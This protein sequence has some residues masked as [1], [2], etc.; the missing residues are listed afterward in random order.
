MPTPTL[1]TPANPVIEVDLNGNPID[2]NTNTSGRNVQGNVAAGNVDAGNPVKIGGYATGTPPSAVAAGQRVNAWYTLN[3]ATVTAL[4]SSTGSFV[5][6]NSPSDGAGLP[7]ALDTRSWGMVFNGVTADRL[8]SASAASGSLGSGLQGAGILG[9]YNASLPTFT[10]GQFGTLAMSPKGAL[11]VMQVDSGGTPV[12]L[13]DQGSD[14][15]PSNLVAAFSST[16]GRVFN[17]T[18]WDRARG[19]VTGTWVHAPQNT[20]SSALSGTIAASGA[21]VA[22]PFVA[23]SRQEVINPSTAAIWAS[24]GT[25]GVNGAGSF[26]ISP[27]GSF[28]TDRTSGTLTLLSTTTTQPYTVNRYS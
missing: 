5:G 12:Q 18:T 2:A 23:T 22:I 25:P 24:W 17:G 26:Q 1:H 8:R 15:L 7:L 9:R 10:D 21:I 28:S 13:T 20:V 19:D 3:G 16:F 6:I 27:G 14:G 11:Q 4:G